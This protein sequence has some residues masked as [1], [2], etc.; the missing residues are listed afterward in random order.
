MLYLK[1]CLMPIEPEEPELRSPVI[2]IK[3]NAIH[4]LTTV[5]VSISPSLVRVLTKG[6]V[7]EINTTRESVATF[8]PTIHNKSTRY[9]KNRKESSK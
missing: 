4:I 9:R 5:S 2:I 3:R 8:I 6:K 1:G 7:F